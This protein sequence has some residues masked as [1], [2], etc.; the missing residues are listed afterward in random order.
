MCLISSHYHILA[1]CCCSSVLLLSFS[2]CSLAL[3][4]FFLLCLGLLVSLFFFHY[5]CAI[6]FCLRIFFLPQLFC[7][8]TQSIPTI[9]LLAGL[10][11]VVPPR[12]NSINKKRPC[13]S[14]PV[15]STHWLP[16]WRSLSPGLLLSSLIDDLL[17]TTAGTQPETISSLS[18][19]P[20]EILPGCFRTSSCGMFSNSTMETSPSLHQNYAWQFLRP[21]RLRHNTHGSSRTWTVF[22]HYPPN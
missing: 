18:R 11:R 22:L 5:H 15:N 6:N 19:T 3:L 17:P 1:S 16:L 2:F 8:C 21:T 9:S 4:D 7:C 10:P 20:P 14:L 13:T 12:Y